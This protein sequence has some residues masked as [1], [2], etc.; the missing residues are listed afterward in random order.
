MTRKVKTVVFV[1]A[2]M[3]P[4]G[5]QKVLAT[6]AN[7]WNKLG[8]K[9]EVLCLRPHQQSAHNLSPNIKQRVLFEKKQFLKIKNNSSS[10]KGIAISGKKNLLFFSGQYNVLKNIVSYLFIFILLRRAL[11]AH[12]GAYVF[13]FITPTNVL[14]ILANHSSNFTIVSERN[15]PTRQSFG[16][17]WSLLRKI[18]YPF[19]D[20]VTANSLNATEFLSKFVHVS[21]L[22]TLPNPLIQ[23]ESQEQH[24]VRSAS[25]FVAVGRLEKQKNLDFLLLS[26]K[27]F[28]RRNGAVKLCI[29]G[30]GSEK[31]YLVQ[32]TKQLDLTND[33]LFAGHIQN[34]EELMK[35]SLAYV[36]TSNYEGTP[37]ALLEA[38]ALGLPT[39]VPNNL[40]GAL[41]Y[42]RHGINGLT[43]EPNDQISLV[44]ML[45]RY[46]YDGEL[47]ENVGKQARNAV[48]HLSLEA[49]LSKWTKILD[50]KF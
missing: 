25:Y 37:N 34:V 30:E 6:I 5:A 2:H 33:V 7:A 17:I 3:G 20:L 38:M 35:R 46:L 18:T 4:G 45:E 24:S 8:Y 39:V 32:L 40:P 11:R 22:E 50:E 49:A 31:E 13:S 16:V 47:R 44:K 48:R 26:L 19:A 12:R 9:V 43:Y 10:Q 15:D 41:E 28:K 29:A 14:T 36:L 1:I 27:E 21:K 42:V 23:R